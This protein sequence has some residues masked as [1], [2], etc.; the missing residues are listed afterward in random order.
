MLFALTHL[1]EN[2]R[3]IALLA[4]LSFIALC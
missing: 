4:V 1:N 3:K 2:R